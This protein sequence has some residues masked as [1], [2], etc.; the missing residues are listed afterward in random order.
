MMKK[1]THGKRKKIRGRDEREEEPQEER[2][3]R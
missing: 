1:Y 2:S 3:G